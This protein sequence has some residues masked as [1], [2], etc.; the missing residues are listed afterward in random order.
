MDTEGERQG[1]TCCR[2][3]PKERFKALQLNR[4]EAQRYFKIILLCKSV[5]NIYRSIIS[6]VSLILLSTKISH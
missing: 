1:T 6:V 4:D 3:Y 5:S 2:G